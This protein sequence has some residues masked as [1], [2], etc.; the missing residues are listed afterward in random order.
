MH[1]AFYAIVAGKEIG[2]KCLEFRQ[3]RFSNYVTCMG[4]GRYLKNKGTNRAG[5]FAQ[6]VNSEYLSIDK[7]AKAC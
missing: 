5:L 6:I 1:K 7:F 4:Y 2:I 3:L